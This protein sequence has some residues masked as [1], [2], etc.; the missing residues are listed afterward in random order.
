MS[1]ITKTR[2][3]RSDEWATPCWLFDRLHAEFNFT[4]DAAAREA[5]L[6][7]LGADEQDRIP[8]R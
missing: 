8:D 6:S 3:P 1:P 7:E 4:L 5:K 2:T